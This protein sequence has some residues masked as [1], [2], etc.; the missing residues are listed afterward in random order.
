MTNMF[1]QMGM[2][3]H[4]LNPPLLATIYP[5]PDPGHNTWTE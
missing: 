2:R 1:T 3:P 4:P 5:D